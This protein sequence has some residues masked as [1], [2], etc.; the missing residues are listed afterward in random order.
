MIYDSYLTNQRKFCVFKKYGHCMTLT[1][2]D[3]FII[4][5]HVRFKVEY[6]FFSS[7]YE[8]D[9]MLSWM[10]SNQIVFIKPLKYHIVYWANLRFKEI[11]DQT[12]KWHSTKFQ[13]IS[14]ISDMFNYQTF[15][16]KHHHQC[17]NKENSH[18]IL[19]ITK[20]LIWSIFLT[21]M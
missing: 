11:F 13:I 7:S 10:P 9:L 14:V 6:D 1:T 20:P 19:T 21:S 12:M 3:F 16:I 2:M 8:T 5:K 18:I 4:S 17:K 15:K